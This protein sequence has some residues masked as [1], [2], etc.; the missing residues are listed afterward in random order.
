MRIR[1][2]QRPFTPSIDGLRLDHLE[3]GHEYEVGNL[4]GALML[5][6]GWAEPVPFEASEDAGVRTSAPITARIP[7]RRSDY[8][9]NPIR[10]RYLSYSTSLPAETAADFPAI[11]SRSGR[12]GDDDQQ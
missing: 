12:P 3:P 1:I 4:V 5:A 2:V 6:E 8:P 10:E 11:Q 7:A 9:R